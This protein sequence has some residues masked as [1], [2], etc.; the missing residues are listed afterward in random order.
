[1]RGT[2]MLILLVAG[3]LVGAPTV[4]AEDLEDGEVCIKDGGPLGFC[5]ESQLLRDIYPGPCTC[6]PP[7]DPW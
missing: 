1:M 2:F 5:V 6:P 3:L 7:N 4:A